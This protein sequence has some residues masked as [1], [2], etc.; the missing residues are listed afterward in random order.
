MR[1][2][3]PFLVGS[4]FPL[5]MIRRRVVI[6]P[7]SI[8]V[9]RSA[10]KERP[11]VSF[12]GHSNTLAAAAAMLGADVTP[13]SERPVLDVGTDNLPMLE[14][15]SFTECW[16]V[17]PSYEPGFRPAVGEEVPLGK[18]DGWQVLRIDWGAERTRI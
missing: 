11:Y 17:A 12:W 8:D 1:N 13:A 14:G 7:T 6:E 9:L 5:A 16:V 2:R 18:I 10:M 15:C 3:G 4:S